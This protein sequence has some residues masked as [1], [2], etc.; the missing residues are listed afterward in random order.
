MKSCSHFKMHRVCMRGANLG[1]YAMS[2]LGFSILS[3]I[4]LLLAAIP[5]GAVAQQKS[6]KEQVV[7]TWILVEAVDV[8]ADGSKTNP[9]GANPKGT[10]MFDTSG[11]FTQMLIRSDL[12]KI[13]NRAQ[14][15]TPEQNKAIV[16]GAIAMYGTYS[17]NE[18][19][20]TIGLRY[21]GSTF[22]AFNGTEGKRIISSLSAEEMKLTN[23]ATSTGVKADSVWRR[24]K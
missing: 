8:A 1:R 19:E 5:I 16:S 20:R 13:N 11:H 10:Y 24:A 17:V 22:S 21:E 15:G 18:A 2:R 3:T 23:P 7:G 14:G 6:L 12:P 9:W 4:A